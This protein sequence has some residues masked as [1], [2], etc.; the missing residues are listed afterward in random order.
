MALAL[1]P[2]SELEAVNIILGV[3]GENPVNSLDVSGLANVDIARQ[4]LHDISREVQSQDWN[5]NT[6]YDYPLPRT[7]DGNIIVPPDT[8]KL[9]LVDD[10]IGRADPVQRGDK[11]YDRKTRSWVFTEDLRFDITFFLPFE[12][13]P[14]QVR[15]YISI[16]AA[17]FFQRRFL[18][19]NDINA[20]TEEEEWAARAGALAADASTAD[21]NMAENYDVFQIMDR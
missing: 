6:E 18:S 12:Q 2:T 16:R 20:F 14:E 1:T 17:R 7:I 8:L 3:V 19:S 15:R 9:D 5:F 13:I 10:L 4:V 21:Y 11:L